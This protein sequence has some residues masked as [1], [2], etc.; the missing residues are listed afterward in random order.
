MK[1]QVK[2][3]LVLVAK[4]SASKKQIVKALEVMKSENKISDFGAFR[5]GVNIY[6]KNGG[7]VFE[8]TY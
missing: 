6:D 1:K 2:S 5:D 7:V 4:N 3:E 8:I